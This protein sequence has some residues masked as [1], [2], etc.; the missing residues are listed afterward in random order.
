MRGIL[1]RHHAQTRWDVGN[2]GG[3]THAIQ[4]EISHSA[5]YGE[6]STQDW[7]MRGERATWLAAVYPQICRQIGL[8]ARQHVRTSRPKGH[9]WRACISYEAVSTS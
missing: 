4:P 5:R 6:E 2:M 8:D 1:G 9:G 7:G 3:T